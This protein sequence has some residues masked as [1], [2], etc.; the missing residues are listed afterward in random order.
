MDTTPLPQHPPKAHAPLKTLG[1]PFC[2]PP[3]LKPENPQARPRAPPGRGREEAEPDCVSTAEWAGETPGLPPRPLTSSSCCRHRR[4][5]GGW[6]AGSG[7]L[8][9]RG[10]SLPWRAWARARGV[11]NGP[12]P[13][14]GFGGGAGAPHA[15]LV[16]GADWEEPE[17]AGGAPG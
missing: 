16:R 7:R 11:R 15:A 3:P 1:L 4:P 5:A 8:R 13:L 14:A 10:R 2:L 17:A 12:A 9:R 6:P